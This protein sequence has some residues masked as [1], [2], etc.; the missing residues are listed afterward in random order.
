MDRGPH[1]TAIKCHIAALTLFAAASLSVSAE[2][3][4]PGKFSM[5]GS[6]LLFGTYD[7]LRVAKPDRE[8]RLKAPG[9]ACGKYNGGYFAPPTIS[10][11][12]DV[13]AWGSRNPT[14]E[15]S[16]PRCV[17]P[18]IAFPRTR[19]ERH[20]TSADPSTPFQSVSGVRQAALPRRLLE[21]WKLQAANAPVFLSKSRACRLLRIWFQL[22]MLWD[23]T[24]IYKIPPS[25]P[26]AFRCASHGTVAFVAPWGST[27]PAFPRAQCS[28]G[29]VQDSFM[30]RL[31]R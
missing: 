10:P 20:A 19:T 5:P 17:F 3:E 24:N 9:D 7:D 13:I 1:V 23:V 6:I 28:S 30:I 15:H 27:A 25:N 29:F 16:P 2:K 18:C 12:G 31:L 22:G 11:R 8:I 4:R 26:H 21:A 14:A